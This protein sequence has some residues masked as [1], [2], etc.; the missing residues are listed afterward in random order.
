MNLNRNPPPG[1]DSHVACADGRAYLFG[2][3]T[4]IALGK[5]LTN[6]PV[7]SQLAQVFD[8]IDRVL[9]SCG[10]DCSALIRI[11]GYLNDEGLCLQ[12]N[13]LYAHCLGE[14]RSVRC[15]VPVAEL[16]YGLMVEIKAIAQ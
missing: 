10:C 4:I 8:N 15:V 9:L 2:Q 16:H 5:P 6:Q 14:H 7:E 1:H 3:L 13:Q 12:F 11:R